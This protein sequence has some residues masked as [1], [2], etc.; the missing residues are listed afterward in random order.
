MDVRRRYG[1]YGLRHHGCMTEPADRRRLRIS[2]IFGDDPATTTDE[3]SDGGSAD[4]REGRDPDHWF[5]ENRPPHHG[6]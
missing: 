3:R 1:V 6:R 4:E 2:E 5:T